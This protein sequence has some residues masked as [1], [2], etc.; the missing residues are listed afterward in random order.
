MVHG[1]ARRGGSLGLADLIDRHGEAIAAELAR[2]GLD[3]LDLYRT[4]P[5]GGPVLSPRRVWRVLRW[6]PIDGPFVASLRG[7]PQ[8]L[9][10]D[11]RMQALAD[12]WNLTAA[13][14]V[15]AKRTPPKYPTPKA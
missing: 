11:R 3:I 15:G 4:G 6:S 9:G 2:I 7:G 12:L 10:W 5:D 8:W 1:A 13:G 14:L